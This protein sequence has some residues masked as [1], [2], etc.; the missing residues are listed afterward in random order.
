MSELRGE[1]L[2]KLKSFGNQEV[3]RLLGFAEPT[4]FP[5]IFKL[6]IENKPKT[7]IESLAKEL[8]MEKSSSEFVSNILR[9]VSSIMESRKKR[10]RAIEDITNEELHQQQQSTEKR[11]KPNEPPV[12]LATGA[13]TTPVV[14]KP[15]PDLSN[16]LKNLQ[17]QKQELQKKVQENATAPKVVVPPIPHQ[18]PAV[19]AATPPPSAEALLQA[20]AQAKINEIKARVAQQLAQL[21]GNA[22]PPPIPTI[23]PPTQSI[24]PTPTQQP[25]SSSFIDISNSTEQ[26]QSQQQPQQQ[27]EPAAPSLMDALLATTKSSAYYDPSLPVPRAN[28]TK[29]STFKF[30][31]PGSIVK[32]AD[33][34]RYK[35]SKE[36]ETEESDEEEEL[37][38]GP[39][40]DIEW[41]DKFLIPT[42]NEVKMSLDDALEQESF[43]NNEITV[44]VEHP[45]PIKPPGE[46]SAIVLPMYLTKNETRKLRKTTRK[47]RMT[48]QQERVLL[49]LE[50]APKAR[51]RIANMM[52]VMAQEQVADPTQIEQIVKKEVAQRKANHDAR[53]EEKKLTPEQ[54]L[55]KKLAK[56]QRDLKKGLSLTVLK[57]LNLDN[58]K[59]RAKVDKGAKE[60][61]LTGV[62]LMSKQFNLVI[63][64]GGPKALRKYKKL[65]LQ[66]I[67]WNEQSFQET[68]TEN[69]N[70]NNNDDE[71]EEEAKP[72]KERDPNALKATPATLIISRTGGSHSV[73]SSS[74]PAGANT[75]TLLWEG[76]ILKSTF[77]KFHI[78]TPENE[79]ALKTYLKSHGAEHLWDLAH[80]TVAAEIVI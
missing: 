57:V 59:I 14:S 60:L 76:P 52:R 49:G 7:Q 54:K 66:R 67:D 74:I 31:E 20:Q 24:L 10:K 12:P 23:Q 53:N 72:T 13:S 61:G 78:Q 9:E 22:P 35:L 77:D 3:Q 71:K 50:P 34:M 48:E 51:V 68:T 47:E 41:W 29:K 2:E 21:K 75:C 64:E 79:E 15:K 18:Q 69:E 1:E 73:V 40:P 8:G 39:V 38:K 28:R 5:A 30:V 55:Q 25:T 26:Q 43:N 45:I 70:N 58:R 19:V 32:R 56:A 46:A 17:Q 44:Y 16:L 62:L 6:I 63:A 36:R 42:K 33:K 27:S 37:P 4:I 80:K 65:L 11:S